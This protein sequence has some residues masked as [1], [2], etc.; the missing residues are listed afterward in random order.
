MKSNQH[1]WPV[2]LAGTVI[3]LCLG[4][5]YSWGIFLLPINEEFGWGRAK[6][7]LA[8]SILLLV[9]FFF[10]SIGGLCENKYG[11]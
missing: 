4:V 1:G 9:F 11:S 10:F 8:V 3:M 2:V 7:S 5:A 6:I